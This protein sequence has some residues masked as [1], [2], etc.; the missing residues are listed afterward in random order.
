[1]R[2]REVHN[3]S[4]ARVQDAGLFVVQLHILRNRKITLYIEQSEW[5][6]VVVISDSPYFYVNCATVAQLVEQ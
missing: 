3:K 5:L 4:F 2:I 1:M 6:R